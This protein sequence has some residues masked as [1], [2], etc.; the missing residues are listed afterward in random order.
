MLVL[1]KLDI[2]HRPVKSNSTLG[3]WSLYDGNLSGG[4][5][6]GIGMALSGACPGTVLV[7]LALGLPSAYMTAAGAVLGAGA[8]VK[9]RHLI[10]STRQ[11][12]GDPGPTAQK[13]TISE[14]ARLPD[15]IS[16]MILGAAIV[17]VLRF[18]PYGTASSLVS[19]S[20]GGFLIGFAQAISLLLTSSPLGASMVY[21]QVS[22]KILQAFDGVWTRPNLPHKSIVFSLGAIAGST[23]LLHQSSGSNLSV[24]DASIPAAHAFVGGIAM[25]F[26]ARLAGG[27]TSGHGLSGL[28][29]ISFSSLVTVAGIFGAGILTRLLV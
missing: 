14:M 10:T 1:E 28:G 20:L 17:A 6:V 22:R 5:L 7:Q 4:V 29:A 19:P 16:Y 24:A 2:L 9:L 15:T 23:A 25:G 11:T 21:E 3:I 27:C 26:G 13:M 8:H 12:R 18:T